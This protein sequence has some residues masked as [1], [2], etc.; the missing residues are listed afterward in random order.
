LGTA[1][2]GGVVPFAGNRVGLSL[3]EEMP[4]AIR[5]SKQHVKSG[6]EDLKSVLI[7]FDLCGFE[8]ADSRS[9]FLA[10]LTL[11]IER[12]KDGYLKGDSRLDR[13]ALYSLAEELDNMLE[14]SRIERR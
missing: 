12:T 7:L 9:T 2:T 10:Q 4:T 6:L 13:D 3:K 11:A 8:E 5:T 14:Q 1:R